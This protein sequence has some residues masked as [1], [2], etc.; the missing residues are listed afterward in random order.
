MRAVGRGAGGD[1]PGEVRAAVGPADI[2]NRLRAGLQRETDLGF[3]L[4][5]GRVR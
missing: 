4:E 3:A 2:A 1:E 5:S